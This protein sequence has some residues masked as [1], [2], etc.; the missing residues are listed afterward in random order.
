M[1][2]G[3][4]EDRTPDLRI[5]NATLSQL[6]YRPTKVAE[7]SGRSGRAPAPGMNVG[8]AGALIA[9]RPARPLTGVKRA[10]DGG[11]DS[12]VFHAGRRHVS[13]RYPY[14]VRGRQ[15]EPCRGCRPHHGTGCRSRPALRGRRRGT[16]RPAATRGPLERAHLA[17]PLRAGEA[18]APDRAAEV[19]GLGQGDRA[20]RGDRVRGSRRRGQ[21]R[22]HQALHGTP[23]PARRAG[24]GA[25]KTVRDRADAVVLPA[26]RRTPARRRRDRDVRSLLVQ[27]RRGRAGDGLLQH[28]RVPGVHPP[29][30]G[31]RTHARTQRRAAVQVL[32]LG[33]PRGAAAPVLAPQEG[34]AE[35]V[36]TFAG[37]SGVA[38]QVGRV[39]ARQGGH[40]HRDRHAG[41]AVD[42]DPLGRQETCAPQCDARGAQRLPL[43]GEGSWR[44]GRGRS[45]DRQARIARLRGWRGSGRANEAVRIRH[46]A[47]LVGA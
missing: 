32:V 31:L 28:R 10:V 13:C 6:S 41:S 34:P 3:A 16:G 17:S 9:E 47:E 14:P 42:G 45:A 33:Q 30:P 37:G 25:G 26:L 29:V 1:S 4:E 40:V 11:P 23:E 43:H 21:G 7:F 36:E 18:P 5:A 12:G 46:P 19:P 8:G 22:H 15:P 44:G 35:A 38:G 20:T 2:G 24:G 39:H 27:P